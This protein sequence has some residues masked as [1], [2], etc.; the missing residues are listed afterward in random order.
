MKL[1][2]IIWFASVVMVLSSCNKFNDNLDAQLNNP[3]TASP[4]AADPDLYLG[5]LELNFNGFF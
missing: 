1:K 5:N 3:S 4:D 2:N